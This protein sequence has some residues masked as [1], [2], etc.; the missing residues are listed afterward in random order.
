MLRRALLCFLTIGCASSPGVW[1]EVT[2]PHF[3]L[4]TDLD[5]ETARRAAEELE[6][7]RDMLISAAWPNA[8]LPQWA[9]DEVYVL[10]VDEFR[11]QFDRNTAAV[12]LGGVPQ[13]FFL[14]GVPENWETRSTL[15]TSPVSIL[16]NQLA[17][18]IAA[19]FYSGAPRWFQEGLAYFL[20]TVH[21]S[22]DRQQVILGA[23]NVQQLRHYRD[24]RS[25]TLAQLLKWPHWSAG[26]EPNW[27]LHGLS[28]MFVHWLINAQAEPFTRYRSALVGGQSPGAAFL[29]AFPDLNTEAT[30]SELFRYSRHGQYSELTVPF[31]RTQVT[32]EDR[33]LTPADLQVVR[34]WIGVASWVVKPQGITEKAKDQKFREQIEA[35]L[36]VEPTNVSAL[37]EDEWSP[38]PTRLSRARAAT[39]AHPRNPRAWELL[40]GL[41]PPAKSEGDLVEHE[42]VLR[43]GVALSPKNPDTLSNLAWLLL[44]KKSVSE[45]V[46]FAMRAMKLAPRAPHVAQTYAGVMANLGNCTTAVQ[47]QE[48]V[49]A[50]LTPGERTQY[51]EFQQNL[52]EFRA[53]C[54]KRRPAR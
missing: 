9:R 15:D 1:R 3:V 41:L 14:P 16:R 7:N 29:A 35:A 54:A 31:R 6:L 38:Q 49:V 19:R 11:E 36:K 28:W 32:L 33:T 23:V 50:R 37:V 48:G 34:A 12:T 2:T 45:A 30:D 4:R 43:K 46:P 22:Q 27:G 52:A 39:V 8:E 47:T 5:A 10:D 20:E 42:N 26:E 21:L 40:A 51:P 24:H 44:R 53:I 13:R 17:T 25:A 18:K